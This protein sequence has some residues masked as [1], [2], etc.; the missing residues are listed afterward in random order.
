MGPTD[1]RKVLDLI[2]KGVKFDPE[3]FFVRGQLFLGLDRKGKPVYLLYPA[4]GKHRHMVV[5]GAS[6]CGKGV[7]VGVYIVQCLRFGEA[8]YWM[9]PK[10]D[11]WGP[12][13]L[14]QE[15]E[16]L[17]L[18]FYLVDLRLEHPQL[19]VLWGCTPAQVEELIVAAL[20]LSDTG[21]PSDHYRLDDRDGAYRLAYDVFAANPSMTLSDL[22]EAALSLGLSD[23]LAMGLRETARHD[24][25]SATKGGAD[26]LEIAGKGGGVYIVGG[27]EGRLPKMQRMLLIRIQQ[28]AA[29]RDRAS[30]NRRQFTLFFDEVRDLLSPPALA[31]LSKIRDKGMHVIVAHQSL[32]DFENVPGLSAA[33][34]KGAI[35]D[36]CLSYARYGAVDSDTG[37]WLAKN[38]GTVL[39]DDEARQVITNA[40]LVDQ[41]TGE[42]IIRQDGR[43]RIDLNTWLAMQYRPGVAVVNGA[44]GPVMVRV[45][46][47]RVNKQPRQVVRG[48]RAPM[49]PASSANGGIPDDDF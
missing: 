41:S 22:A 34:I 44:D 25:L 10:D 21:N 16:K 14:R 31:A 23:G 42:K 39:F 32:G 9:D 47:I 7:F 27:S 38:T 19:N 4:I 40:G 37:E 20:G 49:P 43:A 12:D 29:A 8:I 48:M 24:V 30:S 26:L 45:S 46:P 11:E 13:L 15:C 18:R 2:P 1:I 28:I 3:R 33:Q 17:G 5:S 6:G 35:V 36:N